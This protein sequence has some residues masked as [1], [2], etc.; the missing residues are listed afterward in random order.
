M[1][2]RALIFDFDGTIADTEETHRQA[3]NDA[4][5]RSLYPARFTTRSSRSFSI[6]C[7]KISIAS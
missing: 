2:L 1:N 6:T 4:F 3:F 7:S 5:M